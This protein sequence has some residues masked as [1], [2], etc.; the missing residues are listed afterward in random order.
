LSRFLRIYNQSLKKVLLRA[1]K[2]FFL[3]NSIWVSKNAEFYADFESVEKDLKK[4]PKK[5]ISKNVTEICTFS[6]L[7]MF[8]KLVLLITFLW[9]IF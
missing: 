3:K 9:C 4:F 1:K 8:I 2:K 7:L 6:L 5:V